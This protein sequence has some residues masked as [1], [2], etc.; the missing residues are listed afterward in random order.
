MYKTVIHFTYYIVHK[1]T[2]LVEFSVSLCSCPSP[3]SAHCCQHSSAHLPII[4]N[5]A[6]LAFVSLSP[7]HAA[8]Q[9]GSEQQPSLPV[10]LRKFC[11]SLNHCETL[12][13]HL[14]SVPLSSDVS[15]LWWKKN[16]SVAFCA[17]PVAQ[18]SLQKTQ[19]RVEKL[20]S[21]PIKRA[22]VSRALL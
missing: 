4:S 1:N 17:A 22:Y 10:E 5:Q 14:A 19:Q 16:S 12:L 6:H 7:P 18:N 20:Q 3:G 13:T 2:V 11:V 9:L 21:T 8:H 15:T